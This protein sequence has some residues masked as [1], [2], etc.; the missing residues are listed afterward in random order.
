MHMNGIARPRKECETCG[1]RVRTYKPD[2]GWV[3]HRCV[4][5][6][7]SW[8]IAIRNRTCWHCGDV[9]D[10]EH[11]SSRCDRCFHLMETFEA[12]VAKLLGGEQPWDADADSLEFA[13][14]AIRGTNHRVSG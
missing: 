8:E 6:A 3:C 12:E 11:F 2:F 13:I 5:K 4:S 10:G 14:S 7:I 1:G 9:Q